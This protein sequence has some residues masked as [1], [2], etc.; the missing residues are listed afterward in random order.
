MTNNG[1]QNVDKGGEQA[2]KENKDC[3]SPCGRLETDLQTITI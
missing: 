3:C 1:N 2:A